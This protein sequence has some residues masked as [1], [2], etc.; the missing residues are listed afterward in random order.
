MLDLK[1]TYAWSMKTKIDSVAM[2]GISASLPLLAVGSGGSFTAAHFASTLH[3]WHTAQIGKAVTPLEVADMAPQIQNSSVVFLSAGGRNRD[4]LGAFRKVVAWEPK[5]LTVMTMRKASAL[6][7]LAR[8]YDYVNLLEFDLPSGKDGFLATNSLLAFSV[9]LARLNLQA[10]GDTKILPRSLRQLAHP[11]VTAA[12]HMHRL[13]EVCTPLWSRRQL[14]VLYSPTVQSA[15]I[16]LE[17]KFTEAALGSV[18]MADFRSFGHGR[19]HWLAKRGEDAAVLAISTENDHEIATRTLECI[20]KSIPVVRIDVPGAKTTACLGALVRCLKI[21]QLAGEA[22][23]IDPGRPGVPP[24]GRKLYHLNVFAKKRRVSDM[25]VRQITAI[26]RKSRQDI[27][28]LQKQN[29]LEFWREAH[30]GFVRRIQK[31]RFRGLALDYDGTLCDPEDRLCGWREEVAT[32]VVHL[33]EKGLMIGIATGR[34]DSA[35]RDLRRRIAAQ[36]DERGAMP[37]R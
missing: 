16:D 24:F 30:Q 20:P 37:S 26:E 23:G 35:R 21:T 22:C 12:V 19:H 2:A 14:I 6:G 10:H 15:A 17:S 18:Q 33:L 3:Q 4:I 32:Q 36:N 34:G 25:S 7:D 27:T 28:G 31:G 8:R 13:R 29:M 9:I 11:K 5:Q 1:A